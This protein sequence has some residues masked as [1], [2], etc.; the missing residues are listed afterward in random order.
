MFNGFTERSQRVLQLAAEEAKRLNHNYIG[1]EHLLL[2]IIREGGQASKVLKD[3]GI[4]DEKIRNLIIEIEGKGEEFFNFHEIPLTPRTKRIIE[5]ARNEAR[6]L[7]HNFV[8]PEHMMLALLR[9]GEG[10]A[11]A[12]LAKLGIDIVKARNEILNSLNVGELGQGFK[13]KPGPGTRHRQTNTP[14]LDQYGRDLTELAR[15]G[16]LDPVI[17]RENETERVIEILSR[18]TKNNPCLIG[19]PGVGKTAIAEGL[20]QRIVEGNVPE[21][22]KN[23]RVVTLDL[24]GM[25][26]GSKYRGEFEERIKRVMDEIRRAGNIILFID[27]IHTLVGAGAAEGAIDASNILKPALARG[28]IQVIGATTIDEYR[29]YIEKDSALERRFQPVQ[30][31]EPST[32]ESIL[33]LKGLRD[34]YEAH[35]K[36]KITDE[37]LEAAVNLSHRYITDRFLPDKAIDL[38]DEAAAKV[39]LKNLTAPPDVKNL[40]EEL[41]KVRKEKEEAINTQEF[42]KA[43]KLRDRENEIKNELER[44]KKDWQNQKDSEVP[45]VTVEDIAN[46]VSRW[47]GI[48]VN[49]LTET[50]SEK[51]L[52]LEEILHQRVVG[53]DEAVKAVARA[54][55]RA[56]VGI[57]DPKRPIG[58]FIF[59]GPTGVGK[60]ELSKALAE[61]MFGDENAMIRIDMSEYMEKHT[62]SRLIGSPPGYVGYEEGGQL[63]EKV[64]RKPYSVVLFD[65]IEKAHPDVFNILLQILEDGR[66]TDGKG[67]TVD[68]RNTIVIMTSNVGAQTIKKQQTLGFAAT[69]EKEKEDSYEKMKQNVMED[70]KKTFRPE[71]L[72]RIDEII[73]FHPLE[74]KDIEKI[75]ELML[76]SVINRLKDLEVEI[77]YDEDVIKH[78]SKQGFDPTYGARP[79]RR[80]ITKA[81][82]D[83][84]S[85]EMLKGNIKRG[86]KVV[87]KVVDN[88]IIFEKGESS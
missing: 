83:K 56:R 20:A 38:M 43:A 79:L 52:K 24:S 7:N 88:E 29:K 17:G 53:Q 78:L 63:T 23:K 68:F 36:V 58:S 61:A 34:K 74:D 50:E 80:A 65:E 86:D 76:K 73:V 47:T 14:T 69:T 13:G 18:R 44:I 11:I 42:E 35:H 64:R 37:A 6:N 45:V 71:F 25:V 9:E 77:S 49:K 81:V 33:I 10:V 27:E 3:L 22:L 51:L 70:L 55:R 72:N 30:V 84:L 2:G 82:E 60:T 21:I 31:G 4:D 28:E 62:V 59:L 67:K 15:E 85:E 1:T 12:I 39:R 26:A 5:L 75:A 66:L 41:E 8:A 40:E 57:K 46:V 48:P 54:V 16:K 32:E 87:M 19:E